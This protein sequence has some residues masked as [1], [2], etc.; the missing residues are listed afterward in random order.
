VG[1]E[2][3]LAEEL[4]SLLSQAVKRRLESDVPLGILLSGGIDSSAILACAAD[5]APTAN[6]KTFCIGFDEASFDESSY[7]QTMAD[8]A[9]AK[10][11]VEFCNLEKARLSLPAL[12]REIGE[13][14]GD[15]SLLPTHLVCAFARKNVTAALS[16]DGGDELFAGYDP[17]RALAPSS[18]YQ[19]LAPKKVHPALRFLAGCLP[20]SDRN[21]S[22]DFKLQRWLR[23]VT[24][25]PV[26]W[27]PIWMAALA[28]DEIGELFSAEVKVEDLYS[29]VLTVWEQCESKDIMDRALV[30]FTTFYLQDDILTKT[31]RASMR[32][33]LELRS[34]FL[35]NDV[36]EFA[37]RLPHQLKMRKGRRKYILKKAFQSMLPAETLTRRKKGFGIPLARWLR[38]LPLPAE[39]DTVPGIDTQVIRR[40][41]GRH[42]ARREDNR[43][44][45]WC[46]LTLHYF[47]TGNNGLP[48]P[49]YSEPAAL[50]GSGRYQDAIRDAHV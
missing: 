40:R 29:E 37:R 7:A 19:S 3:A 50:L 35:D 13:P 8:F 20:L 24:Y 46:W 16:G 1:E 18:L 12:L 36:V 23:G 45:I 17:F 47:L 38:E 21:M 4:R 14:I 39:L 11:H 10:H 2:D 41:W 30:Y 25:P 9:G 49:P 44:A 48:A 31:D 26:F 6:L 43:H 28:P 42:R 34:P 22:L 5:H 27:N 32:F 15:P 33:A